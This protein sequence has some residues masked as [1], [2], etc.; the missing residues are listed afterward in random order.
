MLPAQVRAALDRAGRNRRYPRGSL[1]VAEGDEGHDVLIVQS[2]AVKVIT[3]ATNGREVVL[4][5]VHGGAVLGELSAVDG[6]PRSASAYAL[7]PTEV[8]AIT[9]ASF[10]ALLDQHPALARALLVVVAGRLRDANRRQLEFGANDALGRVCQRL[11]ELRQRYGTDGSSGH[12]E[13]EMPFSQSDLANWAGLS[14]EAVV[15][16]LRALRTLGWIESN[17]KTVTMVDEAALL[18]RAAQS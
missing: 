18:R 13:V 15:K 5:V 3:V 7:E 6:G 10:E 9:R 8:L 14:R 1:I 16:G 2:G 4:D 17:G 12:P 11:I